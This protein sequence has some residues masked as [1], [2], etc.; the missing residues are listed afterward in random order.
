M[1]KI[2]AFALVLIMTSLFCTASAETCAL[3]GLT[4]EVPSTYISLGEQDGGMLYYNL[5]RGR[6]ILAMEGDLNGVSL[7]DS[8]DELIAE[9]GSASGVET[10]CSVNGIPYISVKISDTE[11]NVNGIV[12]VFHD[13]AKAY[14][15]MF[16][17]EGELDASGSSAFEEILKTVQLAS[18][19]AG[20]NP[21]PENSAAEPAQEYTTLQKGDKGEEVKHLQER[22]I[23][24]NYLSSGADGDFGNKTKEAVERFQSA[25]SLPITG[26]ADNSTQAALFSESAPKA[27]VYQKM[28]FKELSRNPDNYTGEYY[29]FS[30]KVIQVL[31][32]S[33][34]DGTTSV[35]MR[36]ATKSW[37]DDVVMVNY[38]RS[39][40]ESRILEDDRVTVYGQYQGLLTYSALMG[41][42][43]TVPLFEADQI[44]LK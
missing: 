1:K 12:A 32:S 14:L 38:R 4:F 43:V 42:D 24:L 23:E 25:V 40:G 3:S 6:A 10:D 22:L 37:Y 27:K 19:P 11:N 9:L 44:T 21:A 28:N 20:S 16:A 33:N 7:E 35:Q 30:G 41:N 29:T 26:I 39:A 36:I 5:L 13:E 8:V 34:S 17:V 31:E 2:A 18:N 15:I